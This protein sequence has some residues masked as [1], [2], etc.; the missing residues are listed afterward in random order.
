MLDLHLDVSGLTSTDVLDTMT[1]A[2]IHT[3]LR[4]LES[5]CGPK[6]QVE[7]DLSLLVAIY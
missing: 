1:P 2:S 5:N 3:A 6:L 7:Y 4:L